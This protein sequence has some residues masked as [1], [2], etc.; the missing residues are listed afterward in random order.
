MCTCWW[1]SCLHS[2]QLI[3]INEFFFLKI[4]RNVSIFFLPFY[5]HVNFWGKLEYLAPLSLT[6]RYA[7]L[8]ILI[9]RAQTNKKEK[10]QFFETWGR[11]IWEKSV[12]LLINRLLI[13]RVELKLEPASCVNFSNC[14]REWN[15]SGDKRKCTIRVNFHDQF[16]ME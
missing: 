13:E 11:P 2:S 15:G 16:S 14:F 8:R 4:E 6:I 9:K 10:N 1:Y 3:V 12:L 7:F 5:N